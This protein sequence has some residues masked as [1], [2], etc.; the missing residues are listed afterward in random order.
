MRSVWAKDMQRMHFERLKGNINTDV[1]I[2]GGGIAGIL[3]N[4]KLKNAG[5]IAFWLKL[6]RSAGEL[7]KIPQQ[8]SR[9][10]M[11]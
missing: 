1:L 8:R 7:P 11:A 4:Y 9:S 6:R 10:G 5:L 3:C 2:I